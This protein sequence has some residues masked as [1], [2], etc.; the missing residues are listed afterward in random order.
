MQVSSAQ[1]AKL[2][3]IKK[4]VEGRD[5]QQLMGLVEALEDHEDVQKVYSDFELSEAELQRLSQ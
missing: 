1:L 4:T 2:P 5:A 3:K